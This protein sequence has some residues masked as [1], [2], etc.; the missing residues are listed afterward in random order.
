[1]AIFLSRRFVLFHISFIFLG[2]AYASV[3]FFDYLTYAGVDFIICKKFLGS[4]HYKDVHTILYI[5]QMFLFAPTLAYPAF[6][7]VSL[8][9]TLEYFL[10]Y[11]NHEPDMLTSCSVEE[12]IAHARYI[13]MF[14]LG[15]KL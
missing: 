14:A 12:H 10:R 3:Y 6:V 13:S 15:K 8:D 1:M 7:E 4:I 2:F 9:S 5:Q 11:R